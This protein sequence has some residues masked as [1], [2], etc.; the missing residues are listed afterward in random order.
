MIQTRHVKPCRKAL[1]S[2]ASTAR[3][4][5]CRAPMAMEKEA[6]WTFR[7]HIDGGVPSHGR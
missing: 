3:P 5:S 2:P 4:T 7:T 1:A 6:S